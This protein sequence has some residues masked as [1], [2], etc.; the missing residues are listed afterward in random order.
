MKNFIDNFKSELDKSG[1]DVNQVLASFYTAVANT[2]KHSVFTIL[3][4]EEV[5]LLNRAIFEEQC[6]RDFE[7]QAQQLAHEDYQQ[8]YSDEEHAEMEYLLAQNTVDNGKHD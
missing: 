6:A 5:S 7:E 1:L 3:S 4:K 2:Q 8:R